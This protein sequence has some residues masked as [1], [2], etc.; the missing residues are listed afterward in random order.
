MAEIYKISQTDRASADKFM[1]QFEAERQDKS[2]FITTPTPPPTNTMALQSLAELGVEVNQV[3]DAFIQNY[4]WLKNYQRAGIGG[5][6]LAPT[7]SSS[8]EEAASYYYNKVLDAED[9]T[10][11]AEAEWQAL[12][13]DLSYWAARSD[14]NYSDDELL[15]KVDM[16]KYPTLQKLDEEKVKGH[17]GTTEPRHRLQPG[18]AGRRDLGGPRQRVQR[19]RLH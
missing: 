5:T 2:V 10:R 3:D 6:P 14:R 8:R 4:S 12:Q 1:A 15:A 17:A 11:K 19:R 13:K 9:T 18:C 16:S 7:K